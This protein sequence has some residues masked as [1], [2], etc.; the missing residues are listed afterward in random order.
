MDSFSNAFE[1]TLDGAI[2]DSQTTFDLTDVTAKPVSVP[3]RMRIRAEGANTNEIITVTDVTGNTLTAVRASEPYNGVQTA[4]AHA[5]GATI[6]HVLTAGV[7]NNLSG[8]AGIK[9]SYLGRTT[10]GGSFFNMNGAYAKKITV[11]TAGMLASIDVH[12]KGNS[13]NVAK[14]H[15]F[16]MTDNT[17]VPLR[18]IASNVQNTGAPSLLYTDYI[19]TTARWIAKPINAW[20][21]Q[22][23]YWIVVAG[24]ENN[25]GSQLAYDAT[26]GTDYNGS[27]GWYASDQ[28][29]QTL[30]STTHDYSIR[31][32]FIEATATS[33]LLHEVAEGTGNGT[34]YTTTSSTFSN[35]DGTNLAHSFISGPRKLRFSFHGSGYHTGSAQYIEF[36]ILFDGARIGN[37]DGLAVFNTSENLSFSFEYTTPDTVTAGAHTATVQ[38]RTSSA[39]AHLYNGPHYVQFIVEEVVDWIPTPVGAGSVVLL[40]YTKTSDDTGTSLSAATWTDI[41]PNQTFNIYSPDSNVEFSVRSFIQVRDTG[42]GETFD[43]GRLV[44]DSG[45]TPIYEYFGGELFNDNNYHDIHF[46]GNVFKTGLAAGS[47]TVKAQLLA[48]GGGDFYNRATSSA[49]Y[50]FFR[51]QVIEHSNSGELSPYT[52][53]SLLAKH[54]HTGPSTYSISSTTIADVDSTNMV[55]TFVAPPSGEVLVRLSAYCD[56]NNGGGGTVLGGWGLRSGSTDIAGGLVTRD[57]DGGGFRSL[58]LNVMG[59]IPGTSYT[60]KWSHAVLTAGATL[61]TFAGAGANP[62]DDASAVMQVWAA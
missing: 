15:V 47:H 40:D 9:S 37:T 25:G 42:A 48:N 8:L 62:K 32:L 46:K 28:A 16:V 1:T 35:I 22:G 24:G 34:D 2:D 17:G 23:T 45:G 52:K 14:L 27:G 4:S 59:L 33:T 55:I 18:V 58:D 41:V 53:G 21:E 49:P 6:E 26:G 30:S 20:L 57:P 51:M 54:I 56:I 13:S 60:Y 36:D 50:E 19:S 44:I 29:T 11:S 61:R 39:T 7:M 31:A 43:Q 5:D 3:F 38:W 12:I 10:V